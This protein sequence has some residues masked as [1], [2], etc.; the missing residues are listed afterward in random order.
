MY[1]CSVWQAGVQAYHSLRCWLRSSNACVNTW[2]F[3]SSTVHVLVLVV[4]IFQKNPLRSCSRLR[5]PACLTF[6]GL[7]VKV[8]PRESGCVSTSWSAMQICYCGGSYAFGRCQMQDCPREQ[9]GQGAWHVAL[10]K[11]Q[12]LNRHNMLMNRYPNIVLL[13]LEGTWRGAVRK[14]LMM[15]VV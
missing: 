7:L 9:L 2:H 14:H 6:V 4:R 15:N 10:P 12:E 1:A 8:F 13:E 11:L 5:Y 3:G